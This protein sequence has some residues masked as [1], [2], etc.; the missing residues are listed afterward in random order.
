[1][2]KGSDSGSHMYLGW[3][4]APLLNSCR[5]F[6]RGEGVN[7]LSKTQF[8]YLQSGDNTDNTSCGRKYYQF[9]EDGQTSISHPTCSY[10]ITLTVLASRNRVCVSDL[11]LILSGML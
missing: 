1:M 11:F 9:S 10:N 3:I 2:I 5:V 4:L 8:P 6:L 7:Y